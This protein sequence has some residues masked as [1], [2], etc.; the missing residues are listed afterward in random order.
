MI[1]TQDDAS[2]KKIPKPGLKEHIIKG[3]KFGPEQEP[4]RGLAK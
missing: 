1:I 2:A 4:S 3:H